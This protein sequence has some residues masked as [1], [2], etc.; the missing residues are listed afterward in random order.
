[1]ASGGTMSCRSSA[2][3]ALPASAPSRTSLAVSLRP[4]IPAAP[5]ISTRISA[6]PALAAAPQ[7]EHAEKGEHEQHAHHT[8]RDRRCL[9]D[10]QHDVR[11]VE[12]KE[13]EAAK[14]D[15][16]GDRGVSGLCVHQSVQPPSIG[17][18]VPVVK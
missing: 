10:E 14:Y 4:T 11:Q 18:A 13:T 9:A 12:G 6:L 7:P 5:V 2:V 16:G 1:T 17:I 8:R 3:I 15:G